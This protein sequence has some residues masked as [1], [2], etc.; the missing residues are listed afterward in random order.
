MKPTS[1]FGEMFRYSNLMVA[2]AGYLGA[3]I[4]NPK[5]ELGA[6]YDQAMQGHGALRVGGFNLLVQPRPVQS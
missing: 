2:A 3:S 5:A 1:G 6:G 4:D